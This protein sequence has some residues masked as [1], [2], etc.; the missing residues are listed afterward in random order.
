M[1]YAKN[2]VLYL[3]DVGLVRIL[4]PHGK[5]EEIW[6]CRLDDEQALP[7]FKYRT[8]LNEMFEAETARVEVD[9]TMLAL[10]SDAHLTEAERSVRDKAW[11]LIGGLVELEPDIYF[12]GSRSALVRAV[13][14]RESVSRQTVYKNLRRFWHRGCVPEAVIPN[15]GR[16]G[17]KG[18]RKAVN[19]VKRG[20]PR[21]VQ[22]G[23]GINVDDSVLRLMRVAWS[24]HYNKVK[25][26]FL[27]QAYGWLL[28][29]G[30]PEAVEVKTVRGNNRVQIVDADSVPT[31]EQFAYWYG[32]NNSRPN[33]LLESK[34]LR[35]FEAKY[36]ALLGHVRGEV[37]GPGSRY[38]IDA[39][40]I[41]VYLVSRF[42]PN[43]IIGRATL[44]IV[45]DVFSSMIVGFHL[46]L[47]PPCWDVAILALISTVED[48]IALCARYGVDIE[49]EE[50]PNSGM[51]ATLLAD[52]AEFKSLQSSVLSS[53][54]NV[55]LENARPYAG[56]AK[57]VVESTFR[58]LQVEWGAYLE[59]Y[60]H[61][62]YEKR[63]GPD[64]RLDA[65]LNIDDMR[66]IVIKS[67]LDRN[68]AIRKGFRGDPRIVADNVPYR[69]VSL[70]KWGRDK[71]LLDTRDMHVEFVRREL[72]PRQKIKLTRK[73]L[74]FSKGLYYSCPELIAQ[75]WYLKELDR[76]SWLEASYFPAD[77]SRILVRSPFERTQF[78][79]CDLVPHSQ[80]FTGRS[81]VEITAL[82]RQESVVAKAHQ[83]ETLEHH[84]GYK[85]DIKERV[86]SA[87]WRAE[88]L[89]DPTMSNAERLK[90]IK[91]NRRD[92]MAMQPVIEGEVVGYGPAALP[93]ST[94]SSSASNLDRQADL[95]ALRKMK[96]KSST[97]IPNE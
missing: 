49:P 80:Y 32:V 86:D 24:R 73:G 31:F 65:V 56:E 64:Y 85:V 35:A 55:E 95:K 62:D 76:G 74:R 13:C 78:F 75:P 45:I 44:Y 17:G 69:P 18:K 20:R 52:N 33:R 36:R 42:D 84:L 29:N 60:V 3:Q 14:E 79:T 34:G 96:H 68:H 11:R 2:M 53:A 27:R 1:A 26:A 97:G 7:E 61:K 6:Y 91:Q 12:P 87:R 39:T 10:P 5:R 63:D 54:L 59:G 58:T 41:D 19:D 38:Q 30:F 28:L 16:C 48:K 89:R 93:S 77:M 22:P 15:F 47:E 25:G 46:G 81:Y 70:W 23:Q 67:I 72:L 50:W 4:W 94:Q 82:R 71:S 57:S 66:Y 43:K 40:I 37:R 9:Q 8:E 21:D 92:E 51:C 88:L 83:P 90:K